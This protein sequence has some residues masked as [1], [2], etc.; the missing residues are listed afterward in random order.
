ME[1]NLICI[2]F[3]A[4]FQ[5]IDLALV[6]STSST[7]NTAK[8]WYVATCSNKTS[9]VSPLQPLEHNPLMEM[10]LIRISFFSILWTFKRF[11]SH[12]DVN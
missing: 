6:T 2:F 3:R 7:F 11:T 8:F 12:L 10:Q 1:I 9:L 5:K 4:N